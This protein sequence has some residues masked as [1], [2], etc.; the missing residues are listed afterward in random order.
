MM[1]TAGSQR[2]KCAIDLRLQ[3]LDMREDKA[4]RVEQS[5]FPECCTFEPTVNK[6]P[7]ALEQVVF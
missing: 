1:F 7:A 4:R 5:R 3:A 2:T 6:R